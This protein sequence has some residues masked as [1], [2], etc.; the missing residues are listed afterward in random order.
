MLR[1][2]F[3]MY[4]S[5]YA[6]AIPGLAFFLIFHYGPMYGALIAFK[7]F[8]PRLGILGSPWAG[9]THFTDFFGSYFFWRLVRNTIALNLLNLIWGF[10][11]PIILALLLNEVRH[12]RFKQ[13]IQTVSYLPHFISMVVIC[14]MILEFT[15]SRGVVNDFL[16]ALGFDRINLL[17]RPEYF[18][19]VYVTTEIW[20]QIGWGSIIYLAA[21]SGIDTQL[22]D[23]ADID[24]AGRFRKVISVTLPGIAPTIVVLLI[25]RMGRMM[26][27]GF[28]KIFLLYSPVIYETADVI[29]TFVYRKGLLESNYSFST[30]VGLFN[31][32]ANLILITAAN[33]LSRRVNESSLW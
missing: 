33:A 15:S 18:R 25:L 3:S 31:S 2:D 4:R 23:A 29:Q 30:A 13:T 20:Q 24:G 32:V 10:P 5:L 12:K 16:A 9:F 11:A 27:I 19:T 1:R 22:Y 28:E 21:L 26:S 7:N 17:S 8:S 6:L 14:G